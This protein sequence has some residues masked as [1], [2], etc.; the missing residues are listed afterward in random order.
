M[1]GDRN[2][3]LG[4]FA[5]RQ[6]KLSAKQLAESVID[7]KDD[8]ALGA[9]LFGTASFSDDDKAALESL[10][11]DAVATH[12]GDVQATIQSL[13]QN[14][15]QLEHTFGAV[16]TL[17]SQDDIRTI[18]SAVSP[19]PLEEVSDDGSGATLATGSGAPFVRHKDP[20]A[21][22]ATD[23]G[24]PAPRHNDPNATLATDSGESFV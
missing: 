8:K 2:F 20:D 18:M 24:D 14:D 15:A 10:V 3:L 1:F 23:A 9:S 6:K 22:L 13:V 21:T 12:G 7:A 17:A 16:V 19:A 11:D 4:L 5:V